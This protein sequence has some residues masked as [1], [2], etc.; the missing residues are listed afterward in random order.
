MTVGVTSKQMTTWIFV[1]MIL[2]SLCGCQN[3][4]HIPMATTGPNEKE[5][6]EFQGVGLNTDFAQALKKLGDYETKISAGDGGTI[7]HFDHYMMTTV[8]QDGQERIQTIIL[9]SSAVET[10]EGTVIGDSKETVIQNQGQDYLSAAADTLTY[11]KKDTV[12]SFLLDEDGAVL[13]IQY[14]LVQPE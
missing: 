5:R 13:S 3:H 7:Y 1:V 11:I 12:L 2:F 9:R 14:G 8:A 10:E 4:P 6:Y